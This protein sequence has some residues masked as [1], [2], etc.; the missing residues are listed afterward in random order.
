MNSDIYDD[1]D[2]YE[3]FSFSL[4]TTSILQ[5]KSSHYENSTFPSQIE[6]I[7]KHDYNDELSYSYQNY[8]NDD[9][10]HHEAT[11]QDRSQL[12]NEKNSVNYPDVRPTMANPNNEK[13]FH[14]SST[15]RIPFLPS[16]LWHDLFSKPGILVGKI[17]IF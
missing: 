6:N 13:D 3:E 17:M 2:D 4:S 9:N 1:T 11:N 8:I 7:Q 16:N 15:S 10:L 14:R 5:L 12:F